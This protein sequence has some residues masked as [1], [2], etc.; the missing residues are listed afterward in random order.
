MERKGLLEFAKRGATERVR[1]IEQELQGIYA[2]FPE[3]FPAGRPVLTGPIRLN[4]RQT[5]EDLI[6]GAA[7]LRRKANF[8][9]AKGHPQ[10]RIVSVSLAA[11]LCG[12]YEG[13]IYNKIKSKQ[14]HVVDR[15]GLRHSAR[16]RLTDVQRLFPT[17]GKRAERATV[18]EQQVINDN[19]V[20]AAEPVCIEPVNQPEPAQ[21]PDLRY[22]FQQEQA[23][24]PIEDRVALP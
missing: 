5:A 14:L 15:K 22:P 20:N 12:I 16:V 19:T 4:K 7:E 8:G 24:A 9:K 6:E 2:A 23:A 13:S 17:P 10:G 18:K 1:E 21:E 11:E 3:I